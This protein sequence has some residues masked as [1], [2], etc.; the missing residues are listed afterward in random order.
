[1]PAATPNRIVAQAVLV[2]GLIGTVPSFA[3]ACRGRLECCI[4]L[5]RV[6]LRGIPR[7]SNVDIAG[8]KEPRE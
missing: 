6:Y 3:A 7:A 5:R 1:M 2:V 8:A 4:Q